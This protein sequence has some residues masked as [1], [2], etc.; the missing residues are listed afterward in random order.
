MGGLSSKERRMKKDIFRGIVTGKCGCG[1]AKVA[2]VGHPMSRRSQPPVFPRSGVASEADHRRHYK[3]QHGKTEA[4]R[5][6]V[7]RGPFR[8]HPFEVRCCPVSGAI[9]RMA[10]RG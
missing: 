9:N 5:S 7:P 2:K 6:V 10:F 8:R 3:T 4:D 1:R